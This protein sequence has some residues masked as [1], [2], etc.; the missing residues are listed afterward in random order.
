MI[1]IILGIVM[2]VAIMCC[3]AWYRIVDPSEAHLVVTPS[4]KFV[5]A[6][7][8]KIG[9]KRTYF[10][11]PSSIPFFGRAIRVLP[12]T[13]NE[14]KLEQETIESNQAR[15]NVESSTKFRVID[16]KKAAE[17]F[18]NSKD[19]EG[20]LYEIIMAGTRAV[21]I[22][23]EVQDAR[24]KKQ[25]IEKKIREE[26]TDDF[27]KWGLELINFQLTRF[28]DTK[29]STIISD[30]SRRR[31]VEIQ[32][33]TR[34]DNAN[35]L[36]EAR[37]KEAEAEEKARE[38]E[39]EKDK[40]ISERQQEMKQAIS[41]KEKIAK[42]KE[43]EVK[44]VEIVKAAEIE[45]ER[46]IVKANERLETEKIAKEQKKLEG[47]GNKLKAIEDAEAEA[48]PIRAKGAA[49]AQAKELLQ[50]A[51]NK[52]D[53]KAIRALVAEKVVEKDKLIG[54][55]TAKA[56]QNADLKVF[57]GEGQGFELGKLIQGISVSNEE[58][59]N[60]FLNKLAR[61]NDLGMTTLGLKSIKDKKD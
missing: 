46:A 54:I 11:I 3:F 48:A 14:I 61:P 52:F 18:T 6:A 23:Y 28:R 51:L 50:A 7:D 12:I 17:T 49:E 13:I 2:I 47:E 4:G 56:L 19:L 39:I 31:E 57:S 37:E 53:D 32:S 34:I 10:A 38:R 27:E 59:G 58:A 25:E 43:Y 44:K 24:S 15:Y 22:Q 41:E 42:E 40:I 5:A 29:D 26:I 60:A 36:R 16:V 30:I 8:D 21:T 9:E 1:L 33:K 55:E 35:R 45:K 20:Q